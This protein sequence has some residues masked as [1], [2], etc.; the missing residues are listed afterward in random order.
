VVIDLVIV[1]HRLPGFRLQ[2][3]WNAD[4]DTGGA[5]HIGAF[6]GEWP[7][8]TG[9]SEGWAGN[10]STYLDSTAAG[11]IG[12]TGGRGFNGADLNPGAFQHP[13]PYLYRFG[14][15]IGYTPTYGDY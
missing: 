9:N 8:H 13:L 12:H 4:S 7:R 11:P 5:L 10:R 2:Q 6:A 3:Q 14:N 15:A 1:Y